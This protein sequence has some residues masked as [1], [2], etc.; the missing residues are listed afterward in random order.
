[1]SANSPKSPPSRYGKIWI[2]LGLLIILTPVGLLLPRIFG[3]G[4]AWGE[5]GIDEIKEK[6]G[7][8][9]EGLKKLSE[10]WSAPLSDYSFTDWQSGIKHYAGYMLSGILGVAIVAALAYMLGKFL[11]KG[12]K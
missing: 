7:Y 4:G 1:M 12:E 10:L 8:I 5:W 6:A 3:A 2:A 11:G 9:P